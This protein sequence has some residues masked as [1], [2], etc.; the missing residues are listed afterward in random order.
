M[1]GD[2]GPRWPSTH[3]K[4]ASTSW[5]RED[6]DQDA[7]SGC[8]GVP[9]DSGLVMAEAVHEV[10][11]EAAWKFSSI[12]R[13]GRFFSKGELVNLYKSKVLSY[14]KYRTAAIYH[15]CNTHLAH[16]DAVQM[17]IMRRT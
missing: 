14:V 4:K 13:A 16:V 10:A 7:P 9:I 1:H 17:R 5:Q 3:R 12:L 15:A 6:E 11:S 8:L 2:R